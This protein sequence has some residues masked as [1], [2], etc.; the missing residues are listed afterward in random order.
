MFSNVIR[1]MVCSI[2]SRE[3]F[4][5]SFERLLDNISDPFISE[6]RWLTIKGFDMSNIT[7]SLGVLLFCLQHNPVC[8]STVMEMPIDRVQQLL[9]ILLYLQVKFAEGSHLY[10]TY[11]ISCELMVILSRYEKSNNLI[12]QQVSFAIVFHKVPNLTGSYGDFL[13]TLYGY[14]M[15]NHFKERMVKPPEVPYQLY[16]ASKSL[17]SVAISSRPS[18]SSSRRISGLLRCRLHHSSL[19]P[20]MAISLTTTCCRIPRMHVPARSSS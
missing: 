3:F 15:H 11:V 16:L 12:S 2:E 1:D 6:S 13:L 19:M 18:F 17:M 8:L 9:N 5:R 4:D 20:S 7:E 14:L 10:L